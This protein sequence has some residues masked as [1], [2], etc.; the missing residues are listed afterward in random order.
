M[1]NST[2]ANATG[3]PHPGQRMSA[4]DLVLLATRLQTEFPEYYRYFAQDDFTWAK[5]SQNNRNPLLKM[6]I[7]ADG[8]KTGHTEEAG[9]GLVGSAV[10]GERR[11][12]FMI[13]G[14]Q[15]AADRASEGERVINWAF[16]N[17]IKQTVYE[18][19]VVVGTADVWLGK[20]ATVE[21]Y[22]PTAIK[23]LMPY[24]AVDDYKIAIRY[25]GPIE[26]PIAK[27]AQIATLIIEAKG[28]ATTEY[29]LYAKSN[30][31][32]TGLFGRMKVSAGK[33]KEELLGPSDDR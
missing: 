3:W 23:A 9:Y 8:L 25:T 12:T 29:P 16:R 15:S 19:D 21:L 17:F 13:T 11:V 28:M 7:G 30:V 22:S 1:K 18:K 14:M 4:Q 10:Q 6:G 26:A 31:R 5:I 32:K 33:I 20:K 24:D 2:F 27:D